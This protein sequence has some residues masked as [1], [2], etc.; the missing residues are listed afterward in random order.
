M[1]ERLGLAA[2]SPFPGRSLADYWV[3]TSGLVPRGTTPVLSEH[4][5]ESAFTQPADHQN[6]RRRDVQM[7]VVG[8]GRH[9]VRDGFG[10]EQLY[11]VNRDPFETVNLMDSTEG[12]NEAAIFRRMLYDELARN[13]GSDEAERSYLGAYRQWLKEIVEEK[14]AVRARIGSE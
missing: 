2:G 4:A 13:T 10:I 11:D 8:R 3:S 6:L 1:L 12:R 9:F 5:T 14:T 7:S